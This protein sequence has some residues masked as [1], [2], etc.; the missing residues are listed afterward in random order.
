MVNDF[1]YLTLLEPEVS[2]SRSFPN[3]P[4]KGLFC[5]SQSFIARC[6]RI[7]AVREQRSELSLIQ[8]RKEVKRHEAHQPAT[9]EAGGADR[10]RRLLLWH[11]RQPQEP[12]FRQSQERR[13]QESRLEEPR[14]QVSCACW[15]NQTQGTHQA[16][17]AICTPG[18]SFRKSRTAEKDARPIF[19]CLWLGEFLHTKN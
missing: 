14:L 12:S 10:S 15:C 9:A 17:A 7:G 1:L 6:F 13:L 19:H 16:S 11:W 4:S 2:Q 3:E 8:D 18:G 5:A